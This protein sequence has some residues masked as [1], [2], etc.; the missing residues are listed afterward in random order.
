MGGLVKLLDYKLNGL[1][2]YLNHF[3]YK[4]FIFDVSVLHFTYVYL[5][6]NKYMEREYKIGN[7]INNWTVISDP[8]YENDKLKVK[9]RCKC[10]R[11]CI[12]DIRSVNRGKFS[13]ACKRCGQ[14][15]RHEKNG[16][17]YRR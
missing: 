4:Y 8:F 2:F 16:R 1:G 13:N 10:G 7:E 12:Y 17:V 3:F 6:N 9:L 5:N 14:L 11:E 15:I